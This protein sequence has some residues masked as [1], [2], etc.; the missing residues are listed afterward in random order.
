VP[1][2]TGIAEKSAPRLSPHGP[3]SRAELA[4]NYATPAEAYHAPSKEKA[5]ANR[6][7]DARNR[8]GAAIRS[9]FGRE[10]NITDDESFEREYDPDTVD[11]LD[12]VGM[13]DLPSL[14]AS[15]LTFCRPRSSYTFYPHQ[16]PKL[17]VRPFTREYPQ[18]SAYV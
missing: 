1:V 13:Y 4:D 6:F 11:L 5:F 16:C 2:S 9:L 18:S 10:E 17:T 14:E 15:K 12:V 7:V 3:E 8:A